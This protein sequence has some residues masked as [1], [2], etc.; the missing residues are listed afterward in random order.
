MISEHEQTGRPLQ[1]QTGC[2][3]VCVCVLV[4]QLFLGSLGFIPPRLT[5]DLRAIFNRLG[6]KGCFID[7]T[8]QCLSRAVVRECIYLCGVCVVCCY[9]PRRYDNKSFYSA[10]ACGR[11]AMFRTCCDDSTEQ[12]RW[13]FYMCKRWVILLLLPLFRDDGTYADGLTF[14]ARGLFQFL[15]TYVNGNLLVK[16][17]NQILSRC[18]FSSAQRT[19]STMWFYFCGSRRWFFKANQ[20]LSGFTP[21]GEDKC[22]PPK[23]WGFTVL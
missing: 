4:S 9:L 12:R 14:G 8:L 2:W 16:S 5:N 21:P 19:P 6:G 20:L 10:S 17:L 13:Y 23:S 3:W 1:L 18:D 15:C 22:Q 7:F 11:F